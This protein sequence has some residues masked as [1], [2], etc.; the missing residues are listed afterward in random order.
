MSFPREDFRKDYV[1]FVGRTGASKESL[2]IST[3]ARRPA[4]NGSARVG[5]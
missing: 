4:E 5:C 1:P 3:L 2:R